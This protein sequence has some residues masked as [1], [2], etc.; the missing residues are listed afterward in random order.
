MNGFLASV[1]PVED[2]NS[3]CVISEYLNGE[4]HEETYSDV[5][6]RLKE[7][8]SHIGGWKSTGKICIP[9]TALN[10]YLVT[11]NVEPHLFLKW[12]ERTGLIAKRGKRNRTSTVRHG[13]KV[14]RCA[15]FYDID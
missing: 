10:E 5:F 1:E 11:N 14:V 8:A 9:K 15:I 12:A 6:N 13:N 2:G 4:D 7:N 3:Y